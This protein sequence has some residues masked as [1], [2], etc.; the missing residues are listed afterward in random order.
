MLDRNYLSKFEFACEIFGHSKA[1]NLKSSDV[2]DLYEDWK[3]SE[4]D[5]LIWKVIFKASL[6]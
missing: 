5:F 6:K 4:L 1:R 3:S 2:D